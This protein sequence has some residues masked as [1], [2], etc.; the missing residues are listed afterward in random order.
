MAITK[1]N[2]P[3]LFDLGT[4]NSSLRL[5]SGDTAS[6]PSN[7]NTGEWRYNTDDNY[8]E[9]WDGTAWFQID[10][11]TAV[12]PCTTNTINYPTAVTAY[13]KMEDATDQTGNYN[14]TPTNVNFNVAG[15]FGNAGEFNGSSSGIQTGI[16]QG[17]NPFTWSA[18]LKPDNIT[19]NQY[20]IGVYNSAIGANSSQYFFK[21]LSSN[22]VIGAYNN[23]S[24]E[25]ST[26]ATLGVWSHLVL[27]Y[28]GTG[29]VGY[30]NGAALGAKINIPALILGTK[31]T[32]L[33]G[34]QGAGNDVPSQGWYDG[35]IDQVRIFP[36]AL[37]SDQVTQL[38]NEVQCAPTIVPSE[39]F[40]VNTYV[41][42]G[43][44]QTIDAKFNEAAV[45]N[46]SSSKIQG[47]PQVAQQGFSWSVWINYTDTNVYRSIITYSDNNQIGG[48]GDSI[49]INTQPSGAVSAAMVYSGSFRFNFTHPTTG[50]N[51]GA[52]HHVAFT[53]D[54]TTNQNAV[55]LYVNGIAATSTSTATAASMPNFADF[56]LGYFNDIAPNRFAGKIDQVRIYSSALTQQQ[57]TELYTNE[58][59]ATAQLLDFPVGAGCIAAYELDG[60]ASDVGKTY[61]G[62]PT[63]IGYT[64]MQFAPDLV[65]VKQRSSPTRDHLLNDSLRGANKILYPN[66]AVAEDTAGGV[67][68][69]YFNSFD[70][71]GFTV[72]SSPY[73]NGSSL[74]YAAW[75][76]KAGG[77]VTPDNNTNGTIPSTV[78][79]NP[80][81]GFSIVKYTGNSTAG[82]TVGH[83]LSSVP[84][85]I[86]VKR[87]ST[88]I[89]NWAVYNE[90]IGNT[91]RLALDE[92]GAA[93]PSGRL[94]WN[95]TTP[96][97]TVF[98][99]GNHSAVN[100]NSS[101]IAY[102]FHSVEGFSKIG[103][104]IGTGASG[105]T[106]VTGFEPAFVM[107][108]RT[109]GTGVWVMLD[110]KRNLT[111]PRNSSLYADT[112]AQEDTGSTSGFYPMN[113]YSNG[114]EPIQNTGDYNASGG[115]YI[116][117]AFAADPAPEPVLA[118][119]FDISLYTGNGTT[120]NIYSS[121][122][123]DLV[124]IK[125]RSATWEH[126]L[127]D[128]VRGVA[129]YLR[130]NST[131]AEGT[132]SPNIVS[133]FDTNG[134]TVLGN[135]NSNNNNDT[136]VAW[137]WKAAEIPAINSNGSIP[138]VVSANQAA[139]FSIVKYTGNGTAGAT[140]GHGLGDTPTIIIAKSL[141]GG[142]NWC[143]QFPSVIGAGNSLF[144]N[145]AVAV[146]NHGT[147][148]SD[149]WT[150]TLPTSSVFSIGGSTELNDNGVSVVA[151]CFHSVVGYQKVGSYN[152]TGTSLNQINVGFAPRFVMIKRTN[153]T[154][155]WRMYDNVRGLD[156]SIQAQIP[157]AEYDDTTN[158][159]DFYANGFEFNNGVSY[160]SNPDIN[161]SVGT[162]IYL[163][164]A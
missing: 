55:K 140:I 6:R 137:Q 101:Y 131:G 36:T 61:G 12:V 53:W 90:T 54:G 34:L 138:S 76:W 38:Y 21:L 3:E 64:G 27:T 106:I 117:I 67:G 95:S 86:I 139:G 156:K 5:P 162:Y 135:G 116:F 161:A 149:R 39:H 71:N 78:S 119:S 45:F 104:Y 81:A 40:N 2:T 80:D 152:G 126:F 50:L 11:E 145:S 89:D 59:T 120:Q 113:F 57:V 51:N 133:S 23:A 141:G 18:W 14:G 58:T 83:G 127:Q 142:T 1:I 35:S 115:S 150:Q 129:N 8:V 37:T 92:S 41:G 4:T 48:F 108:K 33:G 60:D 159:L 124:W 72:G 100:Q 146:Q 84:Q 102:C 88:P 97:S 70:S 68:S 75:C 24:Y 25:F 9:Y 69:A 111:N 109:D 110:N 143:T 82:A 32:L 62:I 91:K 74:D 85:M 52:W 128:S 94:E 28:D 148:Q 43:S 155:G 10:Y 79:A 98:T 122:S 46:G 153:S 107:V 44:T 132:T 147:G 29:I 105:N 99:L 22:F 93:T 121:L 114:F 96:T 15:K 130:S 31:Q 17:T 164:I 65:W 56:Y 42:N 158:Y 134:F 123:P 73:Y 47:T 19:T 154:G 20:A 163:A 77:S 13:Y 26:P 63:N 151:Y 30:L 66:L 87:L 125:S 7:P 144:L 157:D 136:Y 49:F 160:Q 103:S 16:Q 118:N 112:P